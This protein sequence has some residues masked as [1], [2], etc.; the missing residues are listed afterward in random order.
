MGWLSPNVSNRQQITVTTY[1]VP[2][3]GLIAGYQLAETNNEIAI[4]LNGIKVVSKPNRSYSGLGFSPI[5][6][7]KTNDIITISYVTN[8]FEIYFYPF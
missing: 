3:E 7:V 8:C 1:H 4:T 6:Y 5:L 2:S